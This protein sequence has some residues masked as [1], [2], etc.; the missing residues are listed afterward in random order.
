MRAIDRNTSNASNLK[1]LGAIEN[2]TS[3][4]YVGIECYV[5]CGILP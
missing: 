3:S 1:I 4:K 2:E 5:G